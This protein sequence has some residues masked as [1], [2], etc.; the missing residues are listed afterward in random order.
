M[1]AARR[2]GGSPP[3][4]SHWSIT[5]G[6]MRS[7]TARAS[8]GEAASTSGK[9]SARPARIRTLWGRIRQ[10]RRTDSV[11]ITATGITGTPLSSASRPTPRWARPSAPGRIRVPSGKISTTSPRARIALAVSI[12]SSSPAPRSTGNAPR[13]FRSHACQRPAKELLLGHVIHRPAG[14]RRDHERIKK[15]PVV[16]R[17]DVRGLRQ[18]GARARSG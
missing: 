7:V 14:H 1:T 12:D 10:P 5:Q 2:S 4:H 17:D 9:L 13:A 11:P 8:A 3:S 16:G 18:E 15:A 6:Q